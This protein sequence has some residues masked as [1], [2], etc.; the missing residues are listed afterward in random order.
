MTRLPEARMERPH[1]A[2]P[3]RFRLPA[4]AALLALAACSADAPPPAA[5]AKAPAAAQASAATPAPPA[6]A[7]PD[8]LPTAKNTVSAAMRRF[9][10][11]SRYHASV[12]TEGGP[13]GTATIEID[14]VAPDRYRMAMPGIGTQTVV[15]DTM[16]MDVGGRVLKAPLPKDALVQWRDPVRIAEH[17]AGMTVQAAGRDNVD[18]EPARKYL[19]QGGATGTPETTLWIDGDGLPLQVRVSDRVQGRATVA[20]IRYSRYDDP[21]IRVEPPQ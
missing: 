10:A 19:V 4:A 21:S 15:G 8:L 16:Y 7:A 18:G 3:P 20:T 11:A 1:P 9:M 5:A 2:L 6:A 14:F 17:E 12:R 13:R